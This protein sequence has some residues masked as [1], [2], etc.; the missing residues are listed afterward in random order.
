QQQHQ[1]AGP[2]KAD[3]NL[4]AQSA[5]QLSRLT[6]GQTEGHRGIRIHPMLPGLQPLVSAHGE[7]YGRGACCSK[8]QRCSASLPPI[9]CWSNWRTAGCSKPPTS[10]RMKMATGC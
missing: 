1:G 4:A 2:A 9:S 5:H 3:Q 7:S 6:S 10:P 8:G